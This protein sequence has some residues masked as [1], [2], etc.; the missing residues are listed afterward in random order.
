MATISI[1][2]SLANG[3]RAGP[4]L[5]DLVIADQRVPLVLDI[6]ITTIRGTTLGTTAG[7]SR[8]GP[9][10]F[11]AEDTTGRDIIQWS[12][13]VSN[14]EVPT[15]H[16]AIRLSHNRSKTGY[17]RISC[18][19]EKILIGTGPVGHRVP[20]TP[21]NTYGR[22]ASTSPF[23]RPS[24]RRHPIQLIHI[25][26]LFFRSDTGLRPNA[27]TCFP[28][29]QLLRRRRRT[30]MSSGRIPRHILH[31]EHLTWLNFDSRIGG[32]HDTT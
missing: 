18:S 11:S 8:H 13:Q 3:Q 19:N 10:E 30:T 4:N 29:F 5:A 27:H 20:Y 1:T 26:G 7:I 16:F 32:H 12:T 28:H 2:I 24:H 22:L 25:R 14:H 9:D 23:F 15:S 6:N 31:L 21:K 17:S